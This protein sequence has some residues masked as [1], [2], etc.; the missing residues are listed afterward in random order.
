MESICSI[1]TNSIKNIKIQTAI[2]LV[3]KLVAID[4]TKM[5]MHMMKNI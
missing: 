2:V 3:V 5:N 4:F 1:L